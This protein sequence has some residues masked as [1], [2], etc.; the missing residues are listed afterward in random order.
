[1]T[2]E[3]LREFCLSKPQVTEDLPFDDDVLV[4]RI[5]GKIFL[6]TSFSEPEKINVKCDPDL[7]IQLR[8]EF[9]HDIIPGYHMNKKHWNTIYIQRKLSNKKIQDLISHSFELVFQSLPSKVKK[10]LSV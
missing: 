7:A 6:L 9:P 4:F 1:M 8:E 2:L 10:E 5:G 3:A